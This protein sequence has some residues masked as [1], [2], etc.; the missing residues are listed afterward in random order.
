MH[1]NGVASKP[2]FGPAAAHWRREV[3]LV[4]RPW[5]SCRNQCVRAGAE[6][7]QRSI[8]GVAP[9]L[10]TPL[11]HIQRWA[12]T[13]HCFKNGAQNSARGV[14][15]HQIAPLPWQTPPPPPKHSIMVGA[16]QLRHGPLIGALAK[17]R[18]DQ[19]TKCW[20]ACWPNQQ[21]NMVA[22]CFQV[23]ADNQTM[24]WLHCSLCTLPS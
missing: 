12:Q 23:V 7:V 9:S 4:V 3:D 19:P 2:G 10:N 6:L 11:K 5:P 21:I 1:S 16:P 15:A 22:A 14:W 20:L 13:A 24:G 18:H 17:L 8:S